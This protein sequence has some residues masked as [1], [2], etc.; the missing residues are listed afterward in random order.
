MKRKQ[1]GSLTGLVTT[2]SASDRL[3]ASIASPLGG[4]FR[5]AKGSFGH[6][7][8]AVGVA[9][10]IRSARPMLD[11]LEAM[12]RRSW[13]SV[14]C[15]PARLFNQ[16]DQLAISSVMKGV[17]AL[18]AIAITHSIE[19]LG[20]PRELYRNPFGS[21]QQLDLNPH[22]PGG[23]LQSLGGFAR[24]A[25]MA[26]GTIDQ[27]AHKW[28]SSLSAA[29]KAISAQ[30]SLGQLASAFAAVGLAGRFNMGLTR[31][32]VYAAELVDEQGADLEA[33]DVAPPILIEAISEA[34]DLA[35]VA[36]SGSR[37]DVQ[38]QLAVALEAINEKFAER[39]KAAPPRERGALIGIAS[40]VFTVIGTIAAIYYGQVSKTGAAETTAD[41]AL[42]RATITHGHEREATELARLRATIDDLVRQLANDDGIASSEDI[43]VIERTTRVLARKSLRS[44][45][46]ATLYP[47]QLVTAIAVE[48][49][50]VRVEY[51]DYLSDSAK[52]GW[53]S[54]KY[55]RRVPSAPSPARHTPADRVP[56]ARRAP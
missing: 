29:M 35:Q 25:D 22:R 43:W 11:T 12:N 37:E 24:L 51:Y 27:P 19:G 1:F 42:L 49:K 8:G 39:M 13:S 52:S 20:L 38:K 47:N 46:V 33:L 16:H 31:A 48:H 21:L 55:M 53:I 32:A 28:L 2:V 40:L 18:N 15:V 14:R 4:L 56:D 44:S 54:K 34:R 26:L 36:Q 3:F 6:D 30:S 45:T 23:G 17:G 41:A 50:W 9:E 7:F 10:R 5:S